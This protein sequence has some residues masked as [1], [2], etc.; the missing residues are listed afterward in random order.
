MPSSSFRR[1]QDDS[2]F[3]AVAVGVLSFASG[4]VYA[5]FAM[6][7]RDR[8]RLRNACSRIKKNLVQPQRMAL[9]PSHLKAPK[10]KETILVVGAGSYGTFKISFVCARSICEIVVQLA[11][12]SIYMFLHL[13]RLTHLTK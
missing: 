8:E 6:R 12:F 7:L 4:I 1:L 11:T 10:D 3:L 13:N 2:L 9:G 5:S